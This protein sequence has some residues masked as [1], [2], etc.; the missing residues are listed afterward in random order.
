[1]SITSIADNKGRVKTLNYC[2]LINSICL[3][4]LSFTNNYYIAIC[5]IVISVGMS[6]IMTCNNLNVII[7]NY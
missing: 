2:W 3:L 7:K 4:L 1:M 5:L 6:Y